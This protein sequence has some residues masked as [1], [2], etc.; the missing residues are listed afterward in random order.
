M[1]F[2]DFFMERV[3]LSVL[4]VF[5]WRREGGVGFGVQGFVVWVA[6]TKKPF[7]DFGL[8]RFLT[9]RKKKGE[10]TKGLCDN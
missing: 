4:F 2:H 3:F 7:F 8:E 6:G 9:P 10:K 5:F 1:F